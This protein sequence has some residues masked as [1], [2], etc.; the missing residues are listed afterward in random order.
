[1]MDCVFCRIRDGQLPATRV[2]EDDRTL[3]IMD[4][5]PIHIHL[6]PRWLHDGKGFDWMLVPG[7]PERIRAAAAKI[8]ASL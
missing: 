4:I 2:A 7:D 1:M 6:I 3:G 5:N 8:R